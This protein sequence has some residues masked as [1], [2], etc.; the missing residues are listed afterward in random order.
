[1]IKSWK[2]IFD[3]KMAIA[4]GGL[5][6]GGKVQKVIDSEVLRRSDPYIP[7]REGIAIKSGPIH[8]KLGSGDVVYQTPYIRKIYNSRTM[9]FNEAPKRGAL[10]FERMKADH[11]INILKDAAKV[12]GEK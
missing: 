9:N 4:K 6:V 3:T 5:E 11:K 12:V 2:L 8:T 7:K 1:M 10:W